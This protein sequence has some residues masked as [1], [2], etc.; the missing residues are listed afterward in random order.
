MTAVAVQAG[1]TGTIGASTTTYPTLGGSAAN[2][3]A[4]EVKARVPFRAAGV[5]TRLY[6][7]ISANNRGATTLTL[8][9]NGADGTNTLSIGDS[10]TGEFEDTTHSDTIASG[11]QVNLKI[12]TGAGGSFFIPIYFNILF[13]ANVSTYRIYT[14][15]NDTAFSTTSTSFYQYLTGRISNVNTTEAPTQFKFKTVASINNLAVY[16]S[17]N[18]STQAVNVFVQKNGSNGTN[19]VSLTASTTGLFEDTAHTDAI[20][21]DDLVNTVVVTGTN[22]TMTI[23]FISIGVR[24]DNKANQIITSAAAGA[25]NTIASNLTTYERLGGEFINNWNATE[26]TATVKANILYACTLSKLECYVSANTIN[27]AST[28]RTRINGANGNQSLSI[29]GLTTGYFEDASNTDVVAATDEVNYQLVTGAT[30]TNMTLRSVGVLATV[31]AETFTISPTGALSPTGAIA[32]TQV[33]QAL[34]GALTPSNTSSIHLHTKQ[35]IV[36][37]G[38][39]VLDI[40]IPESP[41]A[42]TLVLIHGGGW[43]DNAGCSFGIGVDYNDPGLIDTINAFAVNAG[44]LVNVE[45][46]RVP[47]CSGNVDGSYSQ[48]EIDDIDDALNWVQAN[49]DTYNGN[50]DRIVAVGCSAGGQ[51]LLMAMAQ[52]NTAVRLAIGWSAI[53]KLNNT[54][55]VKNY[56]GL[57]VDD[58]PTREAFSP[59]N[60]WPANMPGT[61]VR[62]VGDSSDPSG[63]TTDQWTDMVGKASVSEVVI[64]NLGIHSDYSRSVEL[65]DMFTWITDNLAAIQ[66]FAGT[67]TFAGTL[68]LVVQQS[69]TGVLTSAAA[70]AN[71]AVTTLSITGSLS[72]TGAIEQQANTLL[73]GALTSAGDVA[74]DIST[75]FASVLTSGAA[76][77]NTTLTGTVSTLDVVGVLTSV[78]NLE[79][80][81]IRAA[82]AVDTRVSDW[83]MYRPTI[84]APSS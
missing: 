42:F 65:T 5:F 73:A 32:G 72:P 20:A 74:K 17:A 23:D 71:Q 59:F 81:V 1:N 67:L 75:A 51:L 24:Y 55:I 64:T 39:Q 52:G 6:C 37:S 36:Y 56:L 7:L 18:T 19:T 80:L 60:Q 62:L 57:A 12:I 11:D 61:L 4:T 46:E 2:T 47:V 79:L 69:Q 53:S 33:N 76:L 35:G 28:L 45:Y 29:T 49:I 9:I 34:A 78:G 21:V 27:E 14:T 41:A 8:R 16:V 50:P 70:L 83:N 26:V 38:S 66:D 48:G 54:A 84:G 44:S 25:G 63:L 22:V 40:F 13:A 43:V 10:T 58:A 3:E 68:G 82:T 31:A 15:R 77:E 30:G